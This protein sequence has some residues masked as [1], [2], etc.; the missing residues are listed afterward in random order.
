M[1]WLLTLSE[2]TTSPPTSQPSAAVSSNMAFSAI[3]SIFGPNVPSYA[4]WLL[5]QP[6]REPYRDYHR[7]LQYLSLAWPPESHWALKAPA[8]LYA[9]ETLVAEFPSARIVYLHRD[10]QEVLPSCCAA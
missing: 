3:C 4:E 6:L 7:Q 1:G 5:H 2:H 10:P 9:L 8:H